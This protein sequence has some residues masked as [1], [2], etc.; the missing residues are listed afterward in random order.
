MEGRERRKISETPCSKLR[1]GMLL[2]AVVFCWSIQMVNVLN[3]RAGCKKY[4]F[5]KMKA[6]LEDCNGANTQ[7]KTREV[8]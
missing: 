3:P 6:F 1:K 5:S 8:L 7:G 2:L 4:N